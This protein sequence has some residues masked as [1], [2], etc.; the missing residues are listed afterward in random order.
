MSMPT[1]NPQN[2]SPNNSCVGWYL[3]SF[4]S[5][6]NTL[7]TPPILLPYALYFLWDGYGSLMG[8]YPPE[9]YPT[10]EGLSGSHGFPSCCSCLCL[11]SPATCHH[12]WAPQPSVT[13]A[14][15]TAVVIVISSKYSPSNKERCQER[16]SQTE[17]L[18]PNLSQHPCSHRDI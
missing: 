1:R 16:S 5:G 2:Q 15:N 9:T 14:R 11:G 17:S 18:N 6:S 7:H 3:S 12:L 13:S 4:Y 8:D 10:S